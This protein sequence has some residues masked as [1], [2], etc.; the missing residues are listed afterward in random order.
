MEDR[1]RTLSGVVRPINGAELQV[2]VLDTVH[3]AWLRNCFSPRRSLRVGLRGQ[4]VLKESSQT[5]GDNLVGTDDMLGMQLGVQRSDA[6][7][8]GAESFIIGH[9]RG[10]RTA[11]DEVRQRVGG[12]ERVRYVRFG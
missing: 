4:V 3:S 2:C 10:C 6:R 11:D 12:A 7:V 9:R 5:D 1:K 8:D